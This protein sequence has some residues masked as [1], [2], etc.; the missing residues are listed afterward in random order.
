MSGA[1]GKSRGRCMKRKILL[2]VAS[3]AAGLAMLAVGTWIISGNDATQASPAITIGLDAKTSDN[4]PTDFGDIDDCSRVATN[5]TFDVDIYIMDVIDLLGSEMVFNYQ[6]S[7]LSVEN[8]NVKMFQDA[9]PGSNV[10][11]FLSHPLDGGYFVSAVDIDCRPEDAT[12]CD[13]GSGVLARLTL[14]AVGAGVTPITLG[15]AILKDKNNEAIDDSN[16]DL[17]FDGFI[18]SAWVAVDEQCP[19]EPPPTATPPPTVPPKPSP[20]ASPTLTPEPTPTPAPTAVR[21]R[22]PPHPAVAWRYS[23]YLGPS[24]PTEDA[25]ADVTGD[26]VAAY[27]LRPNQTWGRWFPD[28]PDLSSMTMLDPYDALFVLMASDATWPQEPWGTPPE[29]V[30]LVFGWNSVCYAGGGKDVE[31]ATIG[32]GHLSVL[33]TLTS[34]QTWQRFVP[35]RPDVSTLTWLEPSTPVLV[36]VTAERG[37]EWVFDP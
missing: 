16:G 8:V 4:T 2:I 34:D 17:Y 21:T 19:G 37:S 14:R 13:S 18:T 32:F 28:R 33:Y 23:C 10:L 15:A 11:D 30:D 6:D 7:A 1:E 9:N 35:D 12:A 5:D 27:S 22:T 20:A 24:Q 26:V 36:L 25:L 29:S 31:A 3:A